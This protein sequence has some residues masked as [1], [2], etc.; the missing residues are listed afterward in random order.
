[1]AKPTP[2]EQK[3]ADTDKEAQNLELQKKLLPDVKKMSTWNEFFAH[4]LVRANLAL[5]N[6]AAG[7][8]KMGVPFRNFGKFIA[9]KNFLKF[10]DAK[11]KAA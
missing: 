10:S 2:T 5:R 11:K 6:H 7:V 9:S 8:S 1:M 4:E 3:Q